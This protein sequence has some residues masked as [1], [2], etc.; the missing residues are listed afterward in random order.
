MCHTD[1]TITFTR[2]KK[3]AVHR[4]PFIILASLSYSSVQRGR[5]EIPS[6]T[7][8]SNHRQLPESLLGGN[9]WL[10]I[11]SLCCGRP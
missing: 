10:H 9:I 8:I 2:G 3:E 1:F 5:T 7:V 4:H 6:K 11:D